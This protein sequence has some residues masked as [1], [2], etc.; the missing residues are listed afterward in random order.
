MKR[1]EREHLKEDP[2]ITFI[3]KSLFQFGKYKQHIFVGLGAVILFIAIIVGVKL[4][5]NYSL[6]QENMAFSSGMEIITNED[7]TIDQKIDQLSQLETKKGISQS[8]KITLATL[9]FQKGDINKAQDVLNSI[10]PS[11]VK[12]IDDQKILLKGEILNSSNKSQEAVDTLLKLYAD[13]NSKIAKDFVLFRIANIQLKSNQEKSAEANLK[14]MAEEFPQ[15]QYL[16]KAQTL[17]ADINAKSA[18]K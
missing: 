11:A 2:F 16:R 8:N 4:W 18:E 13:K 15:S 12:L 3:Q 5:N 14:K 9:H 6:S 10:P 1:K 7:L 17:L